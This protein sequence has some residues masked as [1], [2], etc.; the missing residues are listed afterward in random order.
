VSASIRPRC[1]QGEPSAFNGPALV[2]HWLQGSFLSSLPPHRYL[3]EVPFTSRLRHPVA[4][5]VASLP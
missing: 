5:H 2:R 3:L 4:T 1:R